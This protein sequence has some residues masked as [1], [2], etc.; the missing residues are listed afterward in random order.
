[1]VEIWILDIKT[2]VE[3]RHISTPHLNEQ[4]KQT[5]FLTE[6]I[7]GG[8]SHIHTVAEVTGLPMFALFMFY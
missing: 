3:H 8:K 6:E 1:M 7:P 5:R 4:H 2:T